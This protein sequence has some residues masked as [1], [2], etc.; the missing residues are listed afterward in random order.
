MNLLKYRAIKYG[1]FSYEPQVAST[2]PGSDGEWYPVASSLFR[3]RRVSS[4][5]TAIRL[6]IEHSEEYDNHQYKP[7]NVVWES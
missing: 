3:G 7:K 6:C 4:K 5:W 1:A 2:M